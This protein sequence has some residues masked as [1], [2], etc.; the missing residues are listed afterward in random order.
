MY[1]P[2]KKVNKIFGQI[3]KIAQKGKDNNLEYQKLIDDIIKDC[4]LKYRSYAR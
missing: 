4:Y 1:N 3:N 2:R